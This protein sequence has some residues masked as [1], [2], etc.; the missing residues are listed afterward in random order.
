MVIDV[1]VYIAG[2]VQ[3]ALIKRLRCSCVEKLLKNNEIVVSADLIDVKSGGGLIL[4][5]KDL[6]TICK[7]AEKMFNSV[8]QN[9]KRNINKTNFIILTSRTEPSSIFADSD[10]LE[11][12]KGQDPLDNHRNLIIKIIIGLYFDIKMYQHCK[13]Q[14]VNRT[15]HS[16]RH[17][18]T[19]EIIFYGQ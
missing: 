4:P 11:H 16:I 7:Q 5:A 6:V 18:K 8:I 12:I 14:N 17:K 3:K 10:F 1:V 2:F 19:K 13:I 15:K 9:S